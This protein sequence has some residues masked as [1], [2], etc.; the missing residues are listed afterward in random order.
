MKFDTIIIGG[1]LAGLTAGIE[2]SRKGQKCLIVSSGQSAL[3][4]FSGSLE[5]C[6]LSDNPYDAIAS[7]SAEHPYSKIGVERVKELSAGVKSFFKE[8]GATFK[9]Q[10]DANHWRITPLGV[11][12]RAWLTLDE[13][14]TFPSSGELPWKKVA[15][16]NVDGFLDFHTSYIAAGLAEKGVETVVKAVTMPELERLRNNPTEMRSTNIAK[17]LTGDLLGSFAA[18]INEHAK[19]VDAVLM[20][21]VVGLAG[22]TEVVKLKEMVARPLHFLATLPPSVPGI[23]LQMMLKKHFQKLGGTYM[24]GDSVVSGEFENGSLKSIRTANHGDVTFEADNFILAS[25]S[26]FSKGLAS[27]IDGVTEPVF[28]LDVDSIEERA[29]WYKRDMFEAQPYMSFGVA[30]DNSFKAKK[31]GQTVDNL[32]AIGSILS[33]FNAM[34]DGCGAGVAMLTA[35]QVS[36]NILQTPENE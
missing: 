17:T 33:G 12:K 29:Q 16:L 13:Y 15:L 36:S 11:M 18:R 8:V 23:R 26:F 9:G 2:L 34:K 35:M 25:G 1:G 14:A 21:A 5:L 30:T 19:D 24:L 7:L 4:F 31:D 27:T 32:Y 6:S 28:G 3:H 22:C 10:K 20:P